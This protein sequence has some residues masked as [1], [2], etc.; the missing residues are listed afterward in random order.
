[1][2]DLGGNLDLDPLFAGPGDY[3]LAPGSPAIDA[4]APVAGVGDRDLA[5]GERTS[6]PAIDIGAYEFYDPETADADRDG[7]VDAVE[8]AV[9]GSATGLPF[10][11][12]WCSR[13]E[14]DG[15]VY[16]VFGILAD[17]RVPEHFD[18]AIERASG[19]G[20]P[21]PWG[22]VEMVLLS[23]AEEDGQLR[24]EFRSPEPVDDR[25]PG[26]DYYR[27]RLQLRPR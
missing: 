6:D 17:L 1:M 25:D 21:D 9:T 7:F 12:T 11:E 14:V 16:A 26:G 20:S 22:S 4:G 27:L 24:A 19:L 18:L 8:T 10:P 13:A 5:G 3:R 23:Y 15:E 2:I